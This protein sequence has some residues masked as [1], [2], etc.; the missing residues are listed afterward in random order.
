MH[1]HK[2]PVGG[3]SPNFVLLVLN[4][5]LVVLSPRLDH[6]SWLEKNLSGIVERRGHGLH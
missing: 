1:L 6:R 4:R 3:G 2:P 5:N